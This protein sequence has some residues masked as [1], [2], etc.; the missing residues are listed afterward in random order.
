MWFRFC[1]LLFGALGAAFKGT[2]R[3]F[4]LRFFRKVVRESLREFSRFV[5]DI[6]RFR[7]YGCYSPILHEKP[8]ILMWLIDGEQGILLQ[9]WPGP[10]LESQ[11]CDGLPGSPGKGQGESQGAQK[12]GEGLPGPSGPRSPCSGP[13]ASALVLP[14]APWKSLKLA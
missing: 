11:Q 14:W 13:L 1:G 3:L 8:I 6:G 4:S 2:E 5:G 12:M 9:I 10:F 7:A